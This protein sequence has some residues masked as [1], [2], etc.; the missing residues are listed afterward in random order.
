[1]RGCAVSA[2]ASASSAATRAAVS[3]GIVAVVL[4][5][6]F[7]LGGLPLGL[8]YP[9]LLVASVASVTTGMGLRLRLRFLPLLLLAPAA[10]ARGNR[11]SSASLRREL[12]VAGGGGRAAAGIPSPR[13]YSGVLRSCAPARSIVHRAWWWA[14]RMR[15]VV[16]PCSAVTV[17]APGLR[18][19][20][21]SARRAEQTPRERHVH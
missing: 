18:E 16:E 19:V 7:G 8:A 2:S 20:V 9:G 17:T 12:R 1:M 3:F 21:A 6:G 14:T 11:S 13:L 15:G 4:L 10:V 5:L